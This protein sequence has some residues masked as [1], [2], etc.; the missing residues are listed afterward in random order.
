MPALPSEMSHF[1]FR[2]ILLA[3]VSLCWLTLT[4][5]A[6]PLVEIPAIQGPI[7]IDGII[8]EPGWEDIKPFP[9]VTYKPVF[10]NA[11]SEKTEIRIGHDENYL[12]VSGR[13]YDSDPG[14]IQGSGR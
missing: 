1:L 14:G 3:W 2:K 13:M 12:Y 10:G 6:Q 9:M 8:D 5:W 7:I 11:P 4:C